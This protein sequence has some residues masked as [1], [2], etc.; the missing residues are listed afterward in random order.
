MKNIISSVINRH[1]PR[2]FA[3]TPVSDSDLELLFEAARWAPSAFNEQPWRFIKGDK[4]RNPELYDLIFASLV[5]FNQQWANTAPVLITVA[6]NTMNAKGK[7]NR[8]AWYDT[9]QAVGNM[10]AQATS[11]GLFMHQMGGFDPEKLSAS[12]HLPE[13]W[14]A[15]AVIALGYVGDISSLPEAIQEAEIKKI[16]ERKPLTDI[17]F[18]RPF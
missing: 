7:A 10:S 5:E 16:R 2:A 3:N 1:S 11:M 6:A 9:G 4:N 8:H 15:I 17:V 14:Q 18:E 13:G 12:L